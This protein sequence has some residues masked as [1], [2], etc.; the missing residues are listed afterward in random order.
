MFF[1]PSLGSDL[2]DD[3]MDLNDSSSSSVHGGATTANKASDSTAT[4]P[5]ST[6]HSTTLNQQQNNDNN[7][8][9]SSGSAM[10]TS[11][12]S[13][14]IKQ[15]PAQQQQT[16]QPRPV[17]PPSTLRSYYNAKKL[18]LI[19]SFYNAY[20]SCKK[21]TIVVLYCLFVFSFLSS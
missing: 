10:S 18:N 7:S 12:S 8:S 15:S 2:D 17:S 21:H 14:P 3:W 9:S 1:D 16:P 13:S 11:S 6:K 20:S 5:L 19:A 4:S